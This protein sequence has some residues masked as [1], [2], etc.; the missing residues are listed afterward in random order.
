MV[1]PRSLSQHATKQVRVYR[2]RVDEAFARGI[3][4]ELWGYRVLQHLSAEV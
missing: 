1:R 3:H 4:R 2:E